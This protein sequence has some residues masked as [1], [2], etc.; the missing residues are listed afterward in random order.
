M[1]EI[2]KQNNEL[3]EGKENT[4]LRM[5]NDTSLCPM[6]QESNVGVSN[7]TPLPISRLTAYGTAFQP[8]VTAVQTAVNGAEAAGFTMLILPEKQCFKRTVL[9]N[10]LAH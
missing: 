8:L 9:I 6:L 10:L 5:M 4:I 3:P 1:G 2:I 7:Y